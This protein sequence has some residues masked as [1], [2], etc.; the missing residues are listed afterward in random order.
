M[1]TWRSVVIGRP[2]RRSASRSARY[3][4]LISL[5]YAILPP[6]RRS[7]YAAA[8]V[9]FLSLNGNLTTQSYN[10]CAIWVG[11]ADPTETSVW[12]NDNDFEDAGV[13]WYTTAA[14]LAKLAS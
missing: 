6:W 3:S 8:W 9:A 12:S 11:H 13:E 1:E 10:F 4:N 5:M 7:R 14:L 2:Q